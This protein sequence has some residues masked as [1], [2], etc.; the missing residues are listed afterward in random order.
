LKVATPKNSGIHPYS[1]DGIEQAIGITAVRG[2][3]LMIGFDLNQ[4]A[5]PI[6]SLLVSKYKI[7]TGSA[8]KKET[9]R[10]LPPLTITWEELASFVSALKDALNSHSH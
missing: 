9:I 10:L 1:I 6:R 8:A 7:F 4:D 2:K 5:G 3:G